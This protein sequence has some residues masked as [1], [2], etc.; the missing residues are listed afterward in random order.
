LCHIWS[1]LMRGRFTGLLGR[2]R[3]HAPS[4]QP[5]R[6]TRVTRIHDPFPCT[7]A[8]P[9][10]RNNPKAMCP[11]ESGGAAAAVLSRVH[12]RSPVLNPPGPIPHPLTSYTKTV[13]RWSRTPKPTPGAVRSH[14]ISPKTAPNRMEISRF[15]PDR[16]GTQTNPGLNP[17]P[18][19]SRIYPRGRPQSAPLPVIGR[20]CP[21]CRAKK[22]SGERARWRPPPSSARALG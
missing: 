7:N 5:A 13:W 17:S 11:C 10:S 8:R 22:R 18:H 19:A 15:R 3:K 14:G 6:S 16:G 4:N 2:G 21:P 20:S 9:K 12:S 1:P